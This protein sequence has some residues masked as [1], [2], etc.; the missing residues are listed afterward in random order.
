MDQEFNIRPVEKTDAKKII[1]LM[2]NLASQTKYML[3]EPFEVNEN[4]SENEQRIKGIIKDSH[5]LYL[6]AEKEE[7]IVGILIAN[8]KRIERMK[9]VG[10]FILGV[11]KK[12]WGN[13]LG[14]K[15]IEGLLDWAK[16]N[17]LKRLTLEVVEENKSAV[18]LYKKFGFE[19]EGKMI[20]DHYIGNGKYLNSYIMAKI[21]DKSILDVK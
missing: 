9:H 4:L 7:S 18:R 19:I 17:N 2:K 15:L 6:V 8:A 14:S 12:Y 16:E 1:G 5:V 20:A 10:D 13:G 11:D 21:L 3:R